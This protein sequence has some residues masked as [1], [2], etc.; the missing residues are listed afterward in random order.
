[1]TS[2]DTTLAAL[3]ASG[4]K[5]LVPY[6][7]GG[8]SD[9]WLD[10][11]RAAV[12][13]GADV[14]EIGVPFSDPMMDGVVIQR[15]AD[16]SLGRGTTPQSV[17]DDV[18]TL[19]VEIPL[20]VMTYFNV[21]HHMGVTRAAGALHSAGVSG[22]ILPDLP[23]EEQGEWRASCTD[24]DV[25]TINMVAPSTPPARIEQIAK[26]AQGFL[27]ASARMAVT[28]AASDEGHALDVVTRSRAVS[29]M[30][31]YVGIGITTPEQAAAAARIADGAMVGSA[32]VQ[33]VLEGQGA[34]G[35]EAFV[36]EL[37]RAIDA[38]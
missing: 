28:G 11:V 18:A 38:G 27:Y 5:A 25:A 32:L 15:A 6:L 31:I 33:R 4:R 17:L 20:V 19:D 12:H 30:P 34:S 26:I 37:R 21:F 24:V 36:G 29:D 13:A 10:H 23:I 2:L 3:R 22:V 1:M 14:V 8:V 7:V 35:V 9:D 16:V